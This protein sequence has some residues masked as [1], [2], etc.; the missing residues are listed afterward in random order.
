MAPPALN[1]GA[2][3]D[4][5]GAAVDNDT[6]ITPRGHFQELCMLA[7]AALA[8]PR[9]RP[10]VSPAEICLELT[11]TIGHDEVEIRPSLLRR[12]CLQVKSAR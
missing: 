7:H 10:L 12:L 1:A 11:R 3:D 6:V 5:L 8:K 9:V 4:L 2:L